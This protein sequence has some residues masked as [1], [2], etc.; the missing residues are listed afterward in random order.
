MMESSA[1]CVKYAI[2][3]A[4]GAPQRFGS[5]PPSRG[6]SVSAR[7]D[8]MPRSNHGAACRCPPLP[9]DAGLLAFTVSCDHYEQLARALK[10]LEA[11]PDPSSAVLRVLTTEIPEDAITV[12]GERACDGSY[13]CGC[14]KCSADRVAAVK[15]GVRPSAPIPIRRAA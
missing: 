2:G 13:G 8:W 1:H 4:H 15:R 12:D 6:L 9:P 5:S 14:L 10:R 7:E 3:F 11:R